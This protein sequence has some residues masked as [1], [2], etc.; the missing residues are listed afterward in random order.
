MRRA[1][2][3]FASALAVAL[4][5]V[6]LSGLFAVLW[7]LLA[8]P[9]GLRP[10]P[11]AGAAGPGRFGAVRAARPTPR[12]SGSMSPTARW[13]STASSPQ[14]R[15]STPSPSPCR[16]AS[17][18]MS[19]CWCRLAGRLPHSPPSSLS[20]P[21]STAPSPP[22]A[23][24]PRERFYEPFSLTS[25]WRVGRTEVIFAPGR[26]YYFVV[27]PGSGATK[28]GAYVIAVGGAEAFT[29]T[30]IAET[31]R[32]LPVI[33]TGAWSGGPARPEASLCLGAG[34]LVTAL[35]VRLVAGRGVAV[36][37]RGRHADGHGADRARTTRCSLYQ[38][39]VPA[40]PLN[41]PWI[42]SVIQP[43]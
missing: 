38:P 11:R 14:T 25:F 34:L 43:P 4:A 20:S 39:S 28:S 29:G 8:T 40:P 31:F 6:A 26:R 23:P 42:S 32:V 24:S 13:R 41:G 33:W 5:L 9:V 19:S 22:I 27:S 10:R 1:R 37:E 15:P 7:G 18:P 30:D 35:V 17:S 36:A 16:R 3:R 2:V 12:R 21:R